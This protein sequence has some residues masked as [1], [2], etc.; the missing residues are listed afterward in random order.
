MKPEDA[1]RHLASHAAA[2][3]TR[4]HFLGR[5]GIGL[6]AMAL[7][8]LRGEGASDPRSGLPHHRPRAKHVIWLHMSGAPPQHDT[9]DPKPVL[10]AH[11]GELCPREFFEGRR[12]AF[13]RGHPT[14][15]GSPHPTYRAGESG[16][17]VTSLMPHFGRIADKVTLIRSMHTDQFNHAPAD[18]LMC[19]GSAQF[20][21]ASGGAWISWG[22]GSL[23]RDLPTFVVLGSGDSD[24]TGG[25][26]LWGS[27]FLPSEHQGVQLRSSGD[28]VL[29]LSD[30]NGMRR[31]DRRRTLD[32]LAELN[33]LE[34]Q[35]TGDPETL[36]RIEQFELAF[37]MQVAVPEAV[38]LASESAQM[39]AFYGAEP[40]RKSFANNCLMARRLVERGVRFVELFDWGW[41]I[42]G[43][44]P[45]DD[46]MTAFP[47]KCRD[48]DQASAALVLDLEQRGLLDDTLVI[49]SGEFGRTSMNE[50]RGGSKLLGRDHHPD[51]F[52]I[53]VAGGGTKQGHI[54]G[55]TDELG[56]FITEDPVSVRDLQ[57]T[58]LDILGIDGHRF[59]YPYQGLEQRWIGPAADP[60]VV[61]GILA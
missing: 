39:R 33:R 20:G 52:T 21:G 29:Y 28:P 53:W 17:E 46:L 3:T 56:F 40:G 38:D 11:H 61:E 16:V 7:H 26:S 43:T 8:A 45:G 18:L 50:A 23:N 13:T 12:L 57:A 58:V 1:V 6:G 25:K 22:L 51:C 44:N 32:A 15:L 55:S 24:P 48:V 31:P 59:A 37:R 34:H 30:P 47:Q 2:S 35:E 60:K 49:W 10:N 14:L 36:A 5:T 27:G 54:H 4:R 9:F 42:H 41:D 19:T